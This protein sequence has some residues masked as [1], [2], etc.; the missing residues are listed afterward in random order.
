[1]KALVGRAQLM[2]SSGCPH[3]F[4]GVIS[5]LLF[6]GRFKNQLVG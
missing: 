2:I 5:P 4:I 1:M 3:Y 6:G